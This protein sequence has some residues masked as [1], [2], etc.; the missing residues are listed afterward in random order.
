MKCIHCGAPTD[1]AETRTKNAACTRRARVC[2]NGHRFTTYEVTPGAVSWRDQGL[3]T[4]GFERR[5]K[6]YATKKAALRDTRPATVVAAEVGCTAARIR[7]LRR[8]QR[9]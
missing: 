5:A 7:Q 3:A 6:A 8:E 9:G 2:F 1:V 4:A